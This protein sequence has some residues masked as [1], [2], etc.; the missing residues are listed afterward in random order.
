MGSDEGVARQI[1]QRGACF[2]V[3]IQSAEVDF[4]NRKNGMGHF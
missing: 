3:R 1:L 4:R 2:L